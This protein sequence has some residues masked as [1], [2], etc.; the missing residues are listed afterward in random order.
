MR[1]FRKNILIVCEGQRTEPEYFNKIRDIIIDL[2]PEIN[3]DISPKEHINDTGEYKGRRGGKKRQ[4][5]QTEPIFEIENDY[6]AQPTR[7]V[8]EAQIGLEQGTYDEVWAVFD[9]NGHSHHE[10][11]FELAKTEIENKYVNIAFSSISFEFWILLHFE[12]NHTAFIKSMCRERISKSK[13]EYFYCGSEEHANDCHGTK[14]VCGA[15]VSK[16]FLAYDNNT[17]N[18]RFENF[19]QHLTTAIERAVSLKNSYLNATSPIYELNPYTDVYRLVFKLLHLHEVDYHWFNIQQQIQIEKI[20]FDF[21]MADNSITVNI[22]NRSQVTFIINE[23]SV[24]LI[25]AAGQQKNVAERHILEPE[26]SHNLIINPTAILNFNPIF[27]GI[28]KMG[29]EYLIREL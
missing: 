12:E 19:N 11:A 10:Q 2:V 1:N 26:E 7:Y 28:K 16:K 9:K 20:E 4:L 3:I 22:T 29:N 21:A 5:K 13:K 25:D 23:D 8:R 27:V 15:I 14:C 18:F 24:C 17:K 6:T